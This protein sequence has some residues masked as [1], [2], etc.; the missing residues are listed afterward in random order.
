MSKICWLTTLK[1][2]VRSWEVRIADPTYKYYSIDIILNHSS[3]A[4]WLE[5]SSQVQL[6]AVQVN[7]LLLPSVHKE[8]NTRY[9]T[10]LDDGVGYFYN[11][12]HRALHC[13]S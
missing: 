11:D 3:D 4:V 7:L 6:V 9:I 2:K 1:V 12:G 13:V 10:Q 5:G 8:L